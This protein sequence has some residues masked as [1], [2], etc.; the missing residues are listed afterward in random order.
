MKVA[1]LTG[2]TGDLGE[3]IYQAL[4]RDNYKVYSISRKNS[5]VIEN[6]IVSDLSN[7]A[8]IQKLEERISQIEKID[9]VINCASVF[10][11]K[12]IDDIRI[13]DFT[14]SH[15]VNT[16]AP[17]VI[18][19][20]ALNGLS[21]SD[22]PLVINISSDMAIN[23]NQTSMA[24]GTS[25]CALNYLTGNLAKILIDKGIRVNT[26]S[27]ASIDGNKINELFSGSDITNADGG[28]V[29]RSEIYNGIS[30]LIQ[31]KST[32]GENLT[33]SGGNLL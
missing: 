8:D 29:K 17:F 11:F 9:L 2:V 14:E 18:I 25:K 31:N 22:N 30:F 20:G 27:P 5:D 28:R 21:R 26:I 16:I 13:E 23:A 6:G 3:Y 33:I 19:R 32:I 15:L 4:V 10:K 7:S 12:T 24:Y 1:L